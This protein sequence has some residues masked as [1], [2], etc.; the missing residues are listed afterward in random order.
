GYYFSA[1]DIAV[2]AYD[3]RGFGDTEERG[4]WAGQQNLTGDLRQMIL[5]VRELHPNVPLYVLGESMGGAVVINALAEENFPPIDGA[6]LSAPAVWGSKT[7]PPLY[8]ATLW[9]GA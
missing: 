4:I 1:R 6:I 2:Y 8:R 9:T 7:M 5:A 3:Q